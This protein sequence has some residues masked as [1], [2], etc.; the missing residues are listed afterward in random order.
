MSQKTLLYYTKSTR[1]IQIRRIQV[2]ARRRKGLLIRLCKVNG[3]SPG[4]IKNKIQI[5]ETE[6]TTAEAC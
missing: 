5:A 3:P 4:L 1:K 6:K 2:M